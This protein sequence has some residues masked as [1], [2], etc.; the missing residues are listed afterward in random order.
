MPAFHKGLFVA[1]EMGLEG[2]LS[3]RDHQQLKLKA[4]L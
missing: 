2:T 4:L 1:S 3:S